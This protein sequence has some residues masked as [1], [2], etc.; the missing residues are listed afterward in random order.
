MKQ[1]R[2]VCDALAYLQNNPAPVRDLF[3]TRR[4]TVV[5]MVVVPL[6]GADDAAFGALYFTQAAA[7]EFG[8]NIQEAL[9]VGNIH[10]PQA[11]TAALDT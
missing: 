2:F 5:S 4:S 8:G 3:V 1:A 6:L 9:L 11:V 10:Q 7:C